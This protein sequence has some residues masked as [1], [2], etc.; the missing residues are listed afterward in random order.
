MREEPG[1]LRLGSCSILREA[2]RGVLNNPEAQRPRQEQRPENSGVIYGTHSNMSSYLPG[3][4]IAPIAHGTDL[5]RSTLGSVSWGPALAVSKA[6]ITSLFSRIDNGTLIIE[7]QTTGMIANYGQKIAKEYSKSKSVNGNRTNG[8][9]GVN[10]SHKK[11][12]QAQKVEL[13]VK[14]ETFWV[15]LFLFADMGFAESYMLGEVECADL[16]GFFLVSS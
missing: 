7:D 14:K 5:L 13:V 9:N 8:I 3:M 15:R 11:A 1:K 10:K 16:T 12:G 4:I 2:A 6:A